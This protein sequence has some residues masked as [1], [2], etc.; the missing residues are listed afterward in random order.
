MRTNRRGQARGELK[1]LRGRQDGAL[2]LSGPVRAKLDTLRKMCVHPQ[3]GLAMGGAGGAKRP[4]S[5]LELLETQLLEAR[6]QYAKTDA[7][8]R[9]AADAEM[10]AR[11]R[12]A[13]TAGAGADAMELVGEEEEEE[14]EEEEQQEKGEAGKGKGKRRKPKK[15]TALKQRITLLSNQL[16]DARTTFAA[17]RA[18]LQQ[19]QQQQQQ[20]QEQGVAAQ[21]EASPAAGAAVVGKVGAATGAAAAAAVAASADE[22]YRHDEDETVCKICFE[23]FEE[24]ML[25]PCL[26]SFCKDCLRGCIEHQKKCPLCRQPLTLKDMTPVL[27]GRDLA[28][29]AALSGEGEGG[30]DAVASR[31]R[32]GVKFEYICTRVRELV[33]ERERQ[34]SSFSGGQRGGDDDQGEEQGQEVGRRRGGRAKAAAKSKAAPSGVGA[35]AAEGGAP[36]AGAVCGG[37][38]GVAWRPFKAVIFS[39]WTKAL[40]LLA[41]ALEDAGIGC[42]AFL[43]GGAQ[44]TAALAT[45]REQEGCHCLLMCMRSSSHSGHAGLTLTEASHVFLLE[46]TLNFGAEQQAVGR[47]NRIGQELQ[48]CVERLVIEGTVEES[49]IAMVARKQRLEGA[50]GGGASSSSAAAGG[51]DLH[52]VEVEQLFGLAPETGAVRARRAE[53]QQEGGY[54]SVDSD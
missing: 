42:A 37:A 26:H 17:E 50:G 11:A 13:A 46:P 30:D 23:P 49:I 53:R 40:E 34:R 16:E 47:I 32:N 12:E 52:T 3:F 2:S 22:E 14:E 5:I 6:S 8:R 20:Q 44:R 36:A 18:R 1:H 38:T 51:E 28:M 39:S 29:A 19:Q 41:L 48:P 35:G 45:F 54:D 25:T 7:G 27:A 43:G 33:V 24:Q 4:M 21:H 10:A 31:A 9:E 15:P